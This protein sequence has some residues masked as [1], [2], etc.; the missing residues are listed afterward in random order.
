[1]QC[2]S[3][4]NEIDD[5]SFFCDQCGEPVLECDQCHRV[6]KG[7]F[8]IFHQGGKMIKRADMQTGGAPQAASPAAHNAA[9]AAPSPQTIASPQAAPP[10]QTIPAPQAA[11]SSAAPQA[12]H[13]VAPAPA[14]SQTITSLQAAPPPQTIPAPQS[15]AAPQTA[16][17]LTLITSANAT[18]FVLSPNNGD[19]IGRRDGPF[20]KYFSSSFVSGKHCRIIRQGAGWAV[21][22]LGSTNGTFLGPQKLQPGMPCPL[23]HGD[24]LRVAD[25]DLRVEIDGGG[26]TV[27]F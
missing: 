2:L 6:G 4:N 13:T 15:A 25:I 10:P 8:C 19:V 23:S 11:P 14:S 18:G 9:P 27:R 1:M 16:G 5:D 17:A 24:I 20:T 3:C 12:A 26:S 7:K 21:E 22:D